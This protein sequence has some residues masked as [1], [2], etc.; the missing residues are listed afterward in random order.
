MS[1]YQEIRDEFRDSKDLF[2]KILNNVPDGVADQYYDVMVK[3]ND[4][5]FVVL[6]WWLDCKM[7]DTKIISKHYKQIFMTKKG[8]ITQIDYENG[9][10][11]S[12]LSKAFHIT[13]YQKYPN[14]NIFDSESLVYDFDKIY[15]V[16]Q[17]KNF[18]I[19][20]IIFMSLFGETRQRLLYNDPS[21]YLFPKKFQYKDMD[22]REYIIQLTNDYNRSKTKQE[23]WNDNIESKIKKDY[24]Y[25][26]KKIEED[27]NK[28]YLTEINKLKEDH[29]KEIEKLKDYYLKEIADLR[30]CYSHNNYINSYNNYSC[31]SESDRSTL[32][33]AKNEEARHNAELEREFMDYHM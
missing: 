30:Q 15:E 14:I 26:Y 2:K 21:R 4:I 33:D 13:E 5:P 11:N 12:S 25:Q 20:D 27:I 6:L 8:F 10:S 22:F 16:E 1:L 9:V 7:E 17:Y 18:E 23:I 24:Y 32:L 3:N 28:L 19:P 31:L 29:K